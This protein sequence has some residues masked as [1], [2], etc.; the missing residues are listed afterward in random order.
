MA[1][2]IFLGLGQS[3]DTCPSL[4]QLKHSIFIFFLE[5]ILSFS[6]EE[7]LI[8]FPLFGFCFLESFL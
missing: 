5:M 8:F 7:F 3:D 1:F 2:L 4:L 6:L